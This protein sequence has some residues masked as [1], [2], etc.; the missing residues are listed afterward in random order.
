MPKDYITTLTAAA[1]LGLSDGH[2]RRLC[3]EGA[4]K[5][6]QLLGKTW[7]VPSSFKWTPQKPGPKPK[8]KTS[9]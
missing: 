2:V 9:K 1:K 6:A 7:M 4:V 8:E 5:G 3:R